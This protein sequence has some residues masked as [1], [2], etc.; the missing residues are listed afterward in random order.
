[1][2]CHL[3][4]IMNTCTWQK[5]NSSG[6]GV[7]GRQAFGLKSLNTFQSC[8]VSVL[9]AVHVLCYFVCVLA[10]RRDSES[11][12]GFQWFQ[13]ILDKPLY[14]W[15]YEVLRSQAVFRSEYLWWHSKLWV[16]TEP[17]P[18][19]NR[20]RDCLWMSGLCVVTQPKDFLNDYI[21]LYVCDYGH[22]LSNCLCPYWTKTALW[23]S[24]GNEVYDSVMCAPT[25]LSSTQSGH[26]RW[27]G[28]T[29][30][31]SPEEVLEFFYT[32]LSR[33]L[34]PIDALPCKMKPICLVHIRPWVGIWHK[35][36][37]SPH[38]KNQ[39]GGST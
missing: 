37:M 28:H 19:L 11:R 31:L 10:A 14:L 24:P 20:D 16:G 13:V 6:R 1:M 22:Q 7:K 18:A 5:I 2:G 29:F 9:E 38:R 27:P 15:N 4:L 32:Q 39:L 12:L 33:H 17:L 30:M 34:L 25:T 36:P 8:K 3:W 23:G 35:A 21:V 26:H